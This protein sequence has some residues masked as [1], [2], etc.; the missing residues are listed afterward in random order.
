[1]DSVSNVTVRNN[2]FD[3][4][5]ANWG[6]P[7]S[8]FSIIAGGNGIVIENNTAIATTLNTALT[9]DST[10]AANNFVMRS[11]IVARGNYGVKGS[12]TAEGTATLTKYTP[13]SIFTHNVIY[14][15]GLNSGVYPT[16][17]Y[18]APGVADIGFEDLATGN[19]ALRTDSLYKGKGANGRDPG[20]DYA[21]IIAATKTVINGR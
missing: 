4:L 13:G 1:M 5:G 14:G 15:A 20:A 19:V 16:I 10:Y 8:L 11:N 2:L 18:F 3:D 7:P 6:T 9:F 21:A 17:N 12:G